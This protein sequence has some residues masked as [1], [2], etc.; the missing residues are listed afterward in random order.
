L[1]LSEGE[2]LELEEL[3]KYF[4]NFCAVDHL[5]LEVNP[6]E[7]L[8]LLGPSGCGKTTTLN[9]I[10]GLLEPTYGRILIGGR[11]VTY[12]PPIERKVGLV[13]QSYAVFPHM[14]VYENLAFGLKV[15]KMPKA[16]IDK[17]VKEVASL[18]Q[19]EDVLNVKGGKLNLDQ[20]QRTALG[21]A[22]VIEPTFFLLD[23]PLSNLDPALRAVM[24]VKLKQLQKELS[25]T[26][27]YVTHDQLEA[28]SMADRIAVM[29]AG[30][31]Q[32]V[33]T[34]EEVYNNPTNKFVANF[35]GSPTMN[36]I[37]CTLTEKDTRMLLDAED[38]TID[39]T[40]FGE[41]LKKEACG[42]EVVLG[43][44][45]EHVQISLERVKNCIEGK[46]ALVEPLGR[47]TVAHIM[48]SDIHIQVI[49]PANFKVEYG[50]KVWVKF[51]TEHM[52]IFDKKTGKSII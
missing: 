32:Q 50:S 14:T 20:T 39:V 5:T 51:D 28:M 13:F 33:G 46:V 21:R 35:I 36:F 4:G 17:K 24:R 3:T 44:R 41:V 37:D 1:A 11:D 2:K 8:S 45:P 27:V 43:I 12:L 6:G 22:M 47:M 18:L 38:F 15:R 10:A 30:K 9:M 31:L 29:N 25:Q 42:P 26:V 52:H 16:E 19:L 23:E 48:I 34:P 40:R 7:F 49:C